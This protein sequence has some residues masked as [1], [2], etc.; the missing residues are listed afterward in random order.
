CIGQ[1]DVRL[2]EKGKQ[3]MQMLL[4]CLKPIAPTRLI[5]SDLSRCL[6]LAERLGKALSLTVEVRS[7]WRE[8]S[9]GAWENQ[10]WDALR[11]EDPERFEAWVK[12][13]VTVAPPEGESFLKLQSRIKA[14]L[15]ALIESPSESVLVITHAG[16][17]RAAISSA[18]GLPLERAFSIYLNYG[19]LVHLNWNAGIWILRNLNNMLLSSPCDQPTTYSR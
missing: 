4:E 7:E 9:F 3:E 2:S 19:A 10:T 18:I 14:E 17:I 12:D 11:T 15:N 13:F 8:V 5:S 1:S 16:A 6:I